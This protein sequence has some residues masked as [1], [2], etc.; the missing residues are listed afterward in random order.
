MFLGKPIA[1][2]IELQKQAMVLNV[3]HLI[4]ENYRLR[5][6]VSKYEETIDQLV[7]FKDRYKKG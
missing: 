6:K 7:Q 5:A 1:Y 3:D 4:D 2:W